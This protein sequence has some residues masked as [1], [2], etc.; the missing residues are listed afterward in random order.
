MRLSRARVA[1]ALIATLTLAGCAGSNDG[2]SPMPTSPE[3]TDA[4]ASADAPSDEPTEQSDPDESA[5]EEAF[6]ERDQFFEDQNV[7]LGDVLEKPVTQTQKDFIDSQ[8]EYTLSNGGEWS[9]MH[10]QIA[11]ALTFDACE[12][13][14]LNSH[15]V[16]AATLDAHIATSPLFELL[17]QDQPADQQEATEANLTSIMLYGMTYICPADYDQ[18]FDAAATLYPGFFTE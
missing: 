4:P 15:D 13:A 16:D 5:L 9:E 12:N 11:L 18:W 7:P 6:L 14:I 3:V 10:E 17:L 2:D 1:A 8:R